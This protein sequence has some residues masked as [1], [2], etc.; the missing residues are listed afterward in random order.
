MTKISII[1]RTKNESKWI[2][3]CLKSLL[4]Q[5][6]DGG[7][8]IIIVDS[9]STDN[10]LDIVALIDPNIKII[11]PDD[12]EYLPGKFINYGIKNIDKASEYV[13]ILSAHCV[14][15]SSSWLKNFVESINFENGIVAAYCKQIP[16]RSTNYENKRDL[17][18][19]FGDEELIKSKD[20]FFHNA[21]SI[22]SRKTLTEFPFSNDVKHIEDRIWAEQ[23][24][25]SG[26]QI[27]YQPAIS[28]THEHGLN[29]HSNKYASFRGE[30]VAKLQKE[31]THLEKYEGRISQLTDILLIPVNTIDVKL[32]ETVMSLSKHK[33]DI[34]RTH[35]NSEGLSLKQLLHKKL[36]LN[37]ESRKKYYDFI[38]YIN[39]KTN[40]PSVELNELLITGISQNADLCCYVH[41]IQN[42]YFVMDSQ[43]DSL[44]FKSADIMN[45]YNVKEHLKVPC[46]EHGALIRSNYLLNE[47]ELEETVLIS[48]DH[49]NC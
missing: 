38:L 15:T 29:Q 49:F 17:I 26:Y 12:S 41:E 32:A 27:R 16:C 14:P 36:L 7:Q 11:V 30:G 37:L 20:S 40:D 45:R 35:F 18:N 6:F 23:V 46:Y 48:Y 25:N 9:G 21:A 13:V 5:D 47:E 43:D 8:E 24:L 31:S 1:I 33:I 42:D 39:F 10:T 34:D 22:I 44:I 2:G 4:S 28:V 3:Y 19:S